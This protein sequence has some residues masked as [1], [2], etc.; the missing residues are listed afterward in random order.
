[1][2]LSREDFIKA[3]RFVLPAVKDSE[4]Q[5]DPLGFVNVNIE[6]GVCQLTTGN[7]FVAKRAVLTRVAQLEIDGAPQDETATFMI[8]KATLE[9]FL[10]ICAKHKAR[11]DKSTDAT[12]KLVE[13]GSTELESHTDVI[14]YDQPVFSYPDLSTVFEVTGEPTKEMIF[15]ADSITKALK[16]FTGHVESM[17]CGDSV[18]LSQDDMMFQAVFMLVGQVS[19]ES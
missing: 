17:L 18:Y 5:T 9:G 1:M 8:P 10:T 3:A 16:G 13:I 7:G 12:L 14:Q 15:D 11:F 6:G 19:D 2:K 4:Q